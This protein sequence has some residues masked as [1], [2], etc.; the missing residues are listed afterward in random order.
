[1][2]HLRQMIDLMFDFLISGYLRG[3][4][5]DCV[6]SCKRTVVSVGL[7]PQT[8]AQQHDPRWLICLCIMSC[9]P[10]THHAFMVLYCQID[11]W[12]PF[13]CVHKHIY[14]QPLIHDGLSACCGESARVIPK[15]IDW[16]SLLTTFLD[17]IVLCPPLGGTRSSIIVHRMRE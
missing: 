16:F 3:F 11:F 14:D 4:S 17:K 7:H 1:M 15:R 12:T 9:L 10:A 6:S 2:T 13:S 8:R 5:Q